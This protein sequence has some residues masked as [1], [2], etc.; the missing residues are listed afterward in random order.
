MSLI[1]TTLLALLTYATACVTT[2][3]YKL[4]L[5]IQMILIYIYPHI[6]KHLLNIKTNN[7][8]LRTS[9]LIL[10][11][12]PQNPGNYFEYSIFNCPS[13][14]KCNHLSN[15]F[16]TICLSQICL[17]PLLAIDSNS[18]TSRLNILVLYVQTQYRNLI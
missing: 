6:L 3:G 11:T 16:I 8:Q 9:V 14:T 5:I 18:K 12:L 10:I 2:E 4:L 17:S 7:R 1:R 13:Q 15:M